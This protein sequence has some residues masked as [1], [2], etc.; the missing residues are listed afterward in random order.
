MKISDIIYKEEYI[1]STVDEGAEFTHI[2][3]TPE[4]IVEGSLLIIPNSGRMK[5]GLVF[6]TTPVAVI[7]D[8]GCAL[9]ENSPVI[10]VKN[11][12]VA[13]ANACYRFEGISTNGIRIIGITGTNG[14][15]STA[16]FI[17]KIMHRCGHKVGYIGTGI[18]EI[19]GVP[20]SDAHYSMTTPD[21]KL[22]YSSIRRMQNDGCDTIIM[23]VSSHALALDKLAPLS[24]DYGVFT[25]LSREH[26]DF[27]KTI[28][29]YFSAK[30]RL[31]QKCKCGVFNIDDPYVRKA[32]SMC[33]ARRISAGIIWR[34][35]VWA[36]NIEN[37][38]LEGLSYLYHSKSFSYKTR[39][40]IAGSYNTYNSM[41]ASA[42][43]IDMGC[44]PC[45]VK[46]ALA[47]IS[48]LPGRFEII[49]D[50]LSVIIDY[51]H[52]DQA[53]ESIMKEL[54][55]LKRDKRLTVLFGCGGERDK[56]KRPRMAAI[57]EKYADRVIITSDNS[58]TEDIKSII[59]DII[60]GFTKGK[61][62]IIEN[63]RDAIRAVLLCADDNEIVAVIGKGPEKYNIDQSGYT[64]FDE[65]KIILSALEERRSIR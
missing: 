23:E 5:D 15:S 37:H 52:T 51:A 65:R 12:R 36:S 14:K 39:L 57:A 24:F 21:P 35:D 46:E 1:L 18:I 49:K 16:I 9:P 64:D 4:D 25:N 56:S 42:V 13:L 28:E 48:S 2:S 19:D 6:Q 17:K 33:P 8:E 54:A 41:M 29:E 40:N 11:P 60:R 59:A 50:R 32:Y 30:M 31:F 26:L 27:H 3:T 44:K 61:Y 53:L 63:R 55:F 58:R 20:I 7:C 62:E 10:R 34:G 43:C 22:L 47:K 45:E 38:G